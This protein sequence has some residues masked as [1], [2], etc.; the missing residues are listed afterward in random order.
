MLKAL[1]HSAIIRSYVLHNTLI[2]MSKLASLYPCTKRIITNC[3]VCLPWVVS[4]TDIRNL[5]YSLLHARNPLKSLPKE[6]AVCQ[7]V[8]KY[9]RNSWNLKIHY[10]VCTSPPLVPV[11]SLKTAGHTLYYHLVHAQ[12][13]TWSLPLMCSSEILYP[14]FSMKY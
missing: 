7:L 12:I 14:V 1:P 11:F 10:C 13:F 3:H 5:G 8:K 4:I 6:L 9:S 2:C